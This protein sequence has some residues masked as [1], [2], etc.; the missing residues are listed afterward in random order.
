MSQGRSKISNRNVPWVSKSSAA[1]KNRE[2][3][4]RMEGS[5]NQHKTAAS[6]PWNGFKSDRRLLKEKA[7]KTNVQKTRRT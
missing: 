1:T 6:F 5:K 4:N 3:I 2:Y 7:L